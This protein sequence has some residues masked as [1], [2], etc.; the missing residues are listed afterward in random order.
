[1]ISWFLFLGKGSIYVWATGNGGLVD[2]DCNCDGYTSSI[3]TI[4]VGA[5]S[6]YGLSTY[7][8]E[9]CSSTMCVTYTGDSHKG[10][11]EEYKL[12]TTALHHECVKSFRGTSSAAPLAAGIFALVLQANPN[13]TWRD[14]QHIVVHTAQ[15]TSPK[16]D[17][18]K[19]NGANILF[20]HKFGFGSINATALVNAAE[21]WKHVA[22][23]HVCHVKGFKNQEK[24]FLRDGI[25]KVRMWT[26]GC[27]GNTKN[28]IKKLEHV[29]VTVSLKH[30]RRGALSINA[31]SP[32]GT[33]SM[34]LSTRK[35]DKSTA[36]LDDWE[37]MTVH[38]WGEDPR[39]RWEIEFKD[40]SDKLFQKKNTI[41]IEEE[42]KHEIDARRKKAHRDEIP[43]P[44]EDINKKRHKRSEADDLSDNYDK[45]RDEIRHGR[46]G[47][48]YMRDEIA[49][50]D[51]V[52]QLQDVLQDDENYGM[53]RKKSRY[54][55]YL[56]SI[57]MTLYGTDS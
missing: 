30:N 28:R 45:Y 35:Y 15:K 19:Y 24:A 43:R 48:D 29:Q 13:L 7:Y 52:R 50:E 33:R 2:D 27:A 26:D 57:S 34:L 46:R 44:Q 38:F 42:E 21:K 22:E 49:T 40:N 32:S 51:E 18:W 11:E 54:P 9:Q 5:I 10:N 41:D 56:S 31:I 23:Q 1:M 36:G 8:D 16:D 37:F 3:Y 39:G 55:G 47:S 17:G 25:L 6:S 12:I 20:N 14:L 53:Y 4:S